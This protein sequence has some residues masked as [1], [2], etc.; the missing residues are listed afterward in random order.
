MKTTDGMLLEVRRFEW[1]QHEQDEAEEHFCK[2][3]PRKETVLQTP[4][5]V[6]YSGNL[7]LA[8]RL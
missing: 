6:C 3:Q 2:A 1:S 8:E 5:K 4:S 7:L